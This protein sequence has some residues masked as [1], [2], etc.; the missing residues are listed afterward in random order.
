MGAGGWGRWILGDAPGKS[1]QAIFATQFS[2][3]MVFN[4]PAWDYKTFDFGRDVKTVNDRMGKILNATDANLK[5]F[6]S[7]G[8]K[9]ILFHGWNDPALP[10]LNT[11]NYF[12]AVKAA[13]GAEAADSFVRLYMMPG[14]Q[15]CYGGPGPSYCG[16]LS[17]AQADAEHDFSTAL[18]NWVEKGTAPG[19]MI[20]SK[21]AD[22]SDFTSQVTRT[23][24][25]C[26]Y[27][28]T[29]VYKGSGST[30]DAANFTCR[31]QR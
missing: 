11:I 15:H 29:A 28:Q 22:E 14:T 1:A 27:P 9:L 3:N 4:D 23:R 20:A 12:N 13:M 17:A 26:P 5:A 18:E 10:P 30:D 24:P 8:G 21:F 25:L 6:R 31:E 2:A 7:R 16:G 19:R